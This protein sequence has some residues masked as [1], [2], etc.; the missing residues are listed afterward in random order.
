M[1][2]TLPQAGLHDASLLAATSLQAPGTCEQQGRGI[3]VRNMSCGQAS[4]QTETESSHCKLQ[5]TTE[6]L[7]AEALHTTREPL[8]EFQDTHR[9]V[10]D[11]GTNENRKLREANM[12]GSGE[13]TTYT[14]K[15]HGT[16]REHSFDYR[17]LLNA[18]EDLDQGADEASE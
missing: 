8:H 10:A 16:L 2:S 4:I 12:H 11:C 6:H 17:E 9:T 15:T 5:T 14:A 1:N 3:D 18:N 7:A 13:K